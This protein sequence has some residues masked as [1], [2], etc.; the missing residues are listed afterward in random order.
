MRRGIANM[1]HESQTVDQRPGPLPDIRMESGSVMC[2]M[3][4]TGIPKKA[5][6]VIR[7]DTEG[8]AWVSIVRDDTGG[9]GN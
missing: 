8:E 4:L 6:L 3:D 2:I 1:H 7:C 9:H 5:S